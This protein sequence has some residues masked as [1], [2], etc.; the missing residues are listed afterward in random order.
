MLRKKLHITLFFSLAAMATGAKTL[1]AQDT[2][3]YDGLDPQNTSSEEG[4]QLGL[5]CG[6]VSGSHLYFP[7]LRSIQN[8]PRQTKRS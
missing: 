2:P 8:V 1:H 4:R 7:R 3:W 5:L 6:K